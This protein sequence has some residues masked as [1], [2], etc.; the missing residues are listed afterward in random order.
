M[1]ETLECRSFQAAV[2]CTSQLYSS[3]E[4]FAP[5]NHVFKAGMIYGF[6]GDFGCGAWAAASALCGYYSD[7]YDGVLLLNDMP[8]HRNGLKEYSCLLDSAHYT[9]LNS[10]FFP[11]SAEYC[12]KKALKKGK[13][14]R[15]EEEICE[16]FGL[17]KERYSRPLHF[18]GNEL[19]RIS[20][21]VNYA[22]GK[23]I[24]CFP[25]L[26]EHYITYAAHTYAPI[27]QFLR[28]EGKI[29]FVPTSQQE[30]ARSICDRLIYF[31][32]GKATI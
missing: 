17:S 30:A 13:T 10:R 6:T 4:A 21:A 23:E 8:I 12:I 24:Y 11:M 2:H 25:W 27:L 14:A 22:A 32:D 3:R 26:N 19:W 28:E 16:I 29:V 1:I 18:V 20:L 15:T 31:P 5:L 7:D 9:G